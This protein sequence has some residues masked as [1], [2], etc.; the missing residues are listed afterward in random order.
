MPNW[1]E[2]TSVTI[3]VG[4]RPM[5]LSTGRVAKQAA[6]SVLVTQGDTVVL[7]T[8]VHSKPRPGTG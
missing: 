8:V 3:D 2:E 4:D 5:T 6:G 1:F 7:V